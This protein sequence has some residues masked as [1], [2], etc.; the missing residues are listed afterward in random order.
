MV[1]EK[2]TK[3]VGDLV[4]KVT[5][6]EQPLA[7]AVMNEIHR[8]VGQST[9]DDVIA[10]LTNPW[11]IFT[12]VCLVACVIFYLVYYWNDLPWAQQP[13]NEIRPMATKQAVPEPPQRDGGRLGANSDRFGQYNR[14]N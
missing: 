5:G 4:A 9:T 2:L 13:E 8:A 7:D 3:T 14:R 12:L 1:M 11:V 6:K 10:F